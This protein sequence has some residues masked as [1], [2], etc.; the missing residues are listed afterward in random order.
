MTDNPYTPPSSELQDKSQPIPV[1]VKTPKAIYLIA[2][3]FFFTFGMQVS[4]LQKLAL[5]QLGAGP[6]YE[7]IIIS[8]YIA[9][10]ALPIAVAM[11][12]RSALI[13]AAIIM[14]ITALLF[15]ASLLIAIKSGAANLP[16]T[17]ITLGIAGALA[18]SARYCLRSSTLEAAAMRATYKNHV[19]LTKDIQ[20]RIAGR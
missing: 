18:Y 8:S 19:A 5:S 16:M 12:N 11:F 4:A 6:L 13:T 2:V 17:V 10:I 9:M 7:V 20:K 1:E 14:I 15:T 3:F